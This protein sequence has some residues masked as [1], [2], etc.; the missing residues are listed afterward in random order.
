MCGAA[1]VSVLGNFRFHV[2]AFVPT[3]PNLSKLCKIR[4]HLD[5]TEIMKEN[6]SRPSV[7]SLLGTSRRVVC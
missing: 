7:S 2:Y 3:P 5:A 1:T 6:G 4:P